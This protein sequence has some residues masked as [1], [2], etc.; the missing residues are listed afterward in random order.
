[1]DCSLPSM[2]DRHGSND[3]AVDLPDWLVR[4]LAQRW[5][6]VDRPDAKRKLHQGR[7]PL[8]GGVAVY[9]AMVLGL[10]VAFHLP[11]LAAPPLRNLAAALIPAAG[12][13]CFFGALDDLWR[14]LLPARKLVLQFLAVLP[15]V[16]AGYLDRSHRGVRLSDHAGLGSA[17]R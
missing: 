12:L 8:W 1:M 2:Y 11:H 5:Q 15:V 3:V 17:F 13:A 4:G 6:I 7:V 14:I 9:L 16:A 10:L